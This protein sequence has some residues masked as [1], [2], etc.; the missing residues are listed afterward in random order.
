[1]RKWHQDEE[2]AKYS[3]GQSQH[4]YDKLDK[5]YKKM[6]DNKEQSDWFSI[7]ESK[8]QLQNKDHNLQGLSFKCTR[9]K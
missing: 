1:M 9:T 3:E 4:D 5:W 7:A 6:K 2:V 8:T